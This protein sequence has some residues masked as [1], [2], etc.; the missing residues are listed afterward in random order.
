MSGTTGSSHGWSDPYRELRP[1]QAGV[2][3]LS[4]SRDCADRPRPRWTKRARPALGMANSASAS[5]VA[6]DL[7]GPAVTMRY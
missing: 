4:S 7:V 6:G 1:A 5:V 2:Q 3:G